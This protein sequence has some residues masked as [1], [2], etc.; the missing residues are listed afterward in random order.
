MYYKIAQ[1][2][3]GLGQFIFKLPGD[4]SS[5][6][7]LL[8]TNIKSSQIQF[9]FVFELYSILICTQYYVKP[10]FV[11]EVVGSNLNDRV[12][13]KEQEL[14]MHGE[15]WTEWWC[16]H[17][18][19]D[20]IILLMNLDHFFLIVEKCRHNFDTTLTRGMTAPK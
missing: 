2:K 13:E 4:K 14:W 18:T 3:F 8:C 19:H 12:L 10:G 20:R 11:I 1:V 5:T 17:T 16:I 9:Q 6:C 15:A 7:A